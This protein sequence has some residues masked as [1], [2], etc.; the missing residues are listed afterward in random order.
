M[1]GVGVRVRVRARATQHSQA[2]DRQP[3]FWP[4]LEKD[5]IG[6]LTAP[7]P[8]SNVACALL[9]YSR[10]FIAAFQACL[11]TATAVTA[12][13]DDDPSLEF[14]DSAGSYEEEQDECPLLEAWFS[15]DD[16]EEERGDEGHGV[17][18]SRL[19]RSW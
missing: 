16:Q 4:S 9:S 7:P 15:G 19:L 18:A 2:E 11:T 14:P 10:E 12:R 3:F 8:S 1:V 17:A 6:R 5:L 13:R